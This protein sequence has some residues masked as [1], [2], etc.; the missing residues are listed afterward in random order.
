[1]KKAVS[2]LFAFAC[3]SIAFAQASPSGSLYL[4]GGYF[5]AGLVADATVDVDWF[6]PYLAVGYRFDFG[7]FAEGVGMYG[8][9]SGEYLVG[10][11]AGYGGA[12]YWKRSGFLWVGMAASLGAVGVL[13][14]APA[15]YW[16]RL[17]LA[18]E[19]WFM[20]PAFSLAYWFGFGDESTA[21][22]DVG[23]RFWYI[24]RGAWILGDSW[25]A[26]TE[27]LLLIP[28]WSQLRWQAFVRVS[29]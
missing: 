14:P 19:G 26:F 2:I 17:Q 3:A 20:A 8:E 10:C 24:P 23:V 4:E 22:V 18:S 16:Q 7:V 27:I 11:M 21:A 1:M 9:G 12:S 25:M 5:P 29:L 28:V 15:E 13:N 6:S